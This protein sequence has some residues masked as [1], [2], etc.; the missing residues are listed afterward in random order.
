MDELA[1]L[2][3][4]ADRSTDLISVFDR[5]IVGPGDDC[6]IVRSLRGDDLLLTTDQLIEGEHFVSETSLDLIARKAIARSISDLA[7]MAGSPLCSLVAAALPGDCDFADELFDA[8]SRWARHWHCPIV[9]GDIAS[10]DGPL[11]LTVTIVGEPATERSPVLRSTARPGDR[12]FVTGH[13][14]GSLASGRHLS[15]E[16]RLIEADWLTSTLGDRLGAMIDLSDGLGLDASRLAEASGLRI[17]LD[18]IRLPLHAGV[19]GWKQGLGDGED[20]ELCLTASGNVPA[21]CPAT[22]TPITRVGRVVKGAGC[23]ILAP[24]GTIHDTARFGFAH[25]CSSD[26]DEANNQP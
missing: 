23:V 8:M 3:R 1:L 5:V 22:G 19:A 15:F 9:G 13:L 26:A 20:Y 7:A 14:G 10:T 18:A 25:G 16:P 17:E 11:T 6:A 12:V 2:K 24:D 21:Q 4:I